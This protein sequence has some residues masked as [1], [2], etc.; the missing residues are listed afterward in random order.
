MATFQ[1]VMDAA[2]AVSSAAQHIDDLAGTVS[3]GGVTPAQMD[4]LLAAVHASDLP[5]KET[6]TKLDALQNPPIAG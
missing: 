2:N 6:V 4:T 3:V 5:Q 1:D